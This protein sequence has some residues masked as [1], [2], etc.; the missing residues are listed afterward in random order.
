MCK[1]R[2]APADFSLDR[3][4]TRRGFFDLAF[5]ISATG[6]MATTV[7][8]ALPSPAL[9]APTQDQWRYCNKC[10]VLFFD[11]YANKGHCPAGG[12]HRAQGFNFILP[13]DVRETPKAQGA[14]RYCAK[15]H[16]M[17]FDGYPQKG[18][19]PAGGGH[20]A[21]GYVFVLPH[22]VAADP[23]HQGA[24][25]YCNKCHAMF[26]DGYANKGRC[27]AGGGHVAQGYNFVLRRVGNLENDVEGN[28]VRE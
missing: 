15:C 20:A 3:D 16:A 12:G 21:A 7:L 28:P 5:R 24:W 1:D 27:P 10:H 22:D 14:W 23:L 8:G 6:A 13:H 2:K 11:G 26:Y 9:A 4:M 19:C 17:Y 25:R 18:V